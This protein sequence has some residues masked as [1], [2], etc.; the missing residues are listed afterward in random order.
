MDKLCEPCGPCSI[1]GRKAIVDKLTE[2]LDRLMGRGAFAEAYPVALR[3]LEEAEALYGTGTADYASALNDVAAIERNVG[4]YRDAEARFF[5]VAKILRAEFGETDPEYA[6]ALHNLAGLHRMTGELD[7]AEREFGE[8]LGIYLRT[9]PPSDR[10]IVGCRNNLGLVYQ[11]QGRYEEAMACCVEVLQELPEPQTAEDVEAVA[12]TLMNGAACASRMGD[13]DEAS[14]LYDHALGMI[15]GA[16]G[17]ANA[18]FAGALNNV[19]SFHAES[20][21]FEKAEGLLVESLRTTR[22][23]MGE[24]SAP[25]RLVSD[26]LA[27]VRAQSAERA[28]P[29][30]R[31][32]G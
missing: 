5:T 18:T 14:E 27:W 10:R 20:G 23:L 13:R 8:A 25:Y 12:T 15:E 6:T 9:L 28:C 30:D 32:G 3:V 21:D 22:E 2:D 17:R 11:D 31:A 24:T 7:R 1:S 4:R 26:N 16:L 29:A 19:A